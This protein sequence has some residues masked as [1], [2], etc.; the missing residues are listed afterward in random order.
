MGKNQPLKD[1]Y[2]MCSCKRQETNNIALSTH[3]SLQQKPR[4]ADYHNEI[5]SHYLPAIPNKQ[6]S[7][8]YYNKQKEKS[9]S[10][11]FCCAFLF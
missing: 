4:T 8:D 11:I 3:K 6:Y 9:N 7:K 1:G 10:F 2:A 5:L